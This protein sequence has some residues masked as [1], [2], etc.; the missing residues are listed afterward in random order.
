[1]NEIW[2]DIFKNTLLKEAERKS[3][4][5]PVIIPMV[6]YNGQAKWTVPLSF[7]ETLGNYELFTG[8]ILDFKYILINV[9]TYDEKELLKLSGVVGAVFLLDQAD[10]LE[11]IMGR[12]KKLIDTI[13]KMEPE[14]FKLF[15]AWA[16]NILARSFSPGK[17]K[18]ITAILEKTRAEEV[19]KMISNVERVIKKSLKDA[20]HKGIEKGIEKVARQML[21]DGEDISKIIK[22]TGLPRENIERLR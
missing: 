2:R 7:K 16:K 14:E 13:K 10:S 6:L 5:L 12:L 1:M 18:E 22:Y 11:E 20:K 19:E 8:N 3:F 4:R 21:S 9:H 15:V 17:K